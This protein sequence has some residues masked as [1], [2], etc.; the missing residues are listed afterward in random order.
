VTGERDSLD[1]LV[2][3]AAVIATTGV[4]HTGAA[5]WERSLGVNLVGPALGCRA[6][7][8]LMIAAGRGC[9]VNV[10]SVA[11]F[12]GYFSAPYA[13]SKWGLRGLTRVAAAELGPHG[14]R[15]VAV[16]P[17]IV[18]TPMSDGPGSPV[19]AFTSMT[20]AGRALSPEEVA[21]VVVFVASDHAAYL[22]GSDV[23]LDG[24]L[25]AAG[26]FAEIR[27]R[28]AAAASHELDGPAG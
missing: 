12:G 4:R 5:E 13:V 9:I 15:A 3:N 20:P 19:A 1:V 25:L 10:G 21:G 14:V 8:P 23:V 27:R 26:P 22:N 7:A 28:I 11:A 18:E 16:H 17:G 6:V 2:N 24:G